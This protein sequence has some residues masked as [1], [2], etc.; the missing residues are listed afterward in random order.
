LGSEERGSNDCPI[1]VVRSMKQQTQPIQ[2]W[3][4]AVACPAIQLNFASVLACWYDSNMF[5]IR[6]RL[7]I[8]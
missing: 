8:T 4:P 3:F 5:S 6:I 2:L 7:A 1:D